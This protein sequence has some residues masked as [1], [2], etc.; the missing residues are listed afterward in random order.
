MIKK[1]R[2]LWIILSVLVVYVIVNLPLFYSILYVH[3]VKGIGKLWGYAPNQFL[4][5]VLVFPISTFF[6]FHIL[7]FFVKD[8]YRSIPLNSKI[9]YVFEHFPIFLLCC[10][11]VTCSLT[12]V[13][14]YT[15]AW[16]FDKLEPKYAEKTLESIDKFEKLIEDSSKRKDEQESTRKQLIREAKNKLTDV[17]GKIPSKYDPDEVDKLL[18]ELEPSVYLQIAHNRY[19]SHKLRIINPTIQFLNVVQLFIVLAI[20]SSILFVTIIS[21]IFAREI[22]YD[23]SNHAELKQILH[24]IFWSVFYFSFYVIC[25]QQYRFQIEEYVGK[26]TTIYQDALTFLVVLALLIGIK[27]I[28]TS[29]LDFSAKDLTVFLPILAPVSGL[30]L[31]YFAP[32]TMKQYIGTETTMGFQIIFSI[33]FLGLSLIP[34]YTSMKF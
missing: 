18:N 13:I 19:F 9:A 11:I 26:G 16:S 4:F 22:H 15:S 20:A 2:M 17:Q 33:I 7:V 23:G 3:G 32:A 12:I 5:L 10:V 28:E 34:I 30:T 27:Y 29:K 6:A 25:F 31:E 24:L 8:L 21:L 1:K 14:Y